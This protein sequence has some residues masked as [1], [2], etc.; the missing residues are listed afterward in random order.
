MV[1]RAL[2]LAGVLLGGCAA[3]DPCPDGPMT[4]GEEG[5]V[6][7]AAEHGDAW[8]RGQC[9]GC[10]AEAVLHRTGCTPDVDLD[11]VRALVAADGVASCAACHGDNGGGD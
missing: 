11:E 7:T 10:H 6:V 3:E 8:G 5:L 1:I 9:F 2:L 4:E